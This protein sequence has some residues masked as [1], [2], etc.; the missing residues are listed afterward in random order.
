MSKGMLSLIGCIDGD[1]YGWKPLISENEK[2]DNKKKSKSHR[3][4]K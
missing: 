2:I 4:L 1:Y 3:I